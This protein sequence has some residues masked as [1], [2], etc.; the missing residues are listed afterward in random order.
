M[1]EQMLKDPKTYLQEYTQRKKQSPQYRI[2]REYAP[3]HA[4]QFEVE[5]TALG[6]TAKGTGRSKKLAELA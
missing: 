4:K 6:K 5:L 3:D 2:L 1:T